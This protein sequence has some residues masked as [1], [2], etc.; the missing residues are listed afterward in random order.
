MDPDFQRAGAPRRLGRCYFFWNVD[1][2][3]FG[4][5]IQRTYSLPSTERLI[6]NC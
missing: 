4:S 5:H 6:F 1:T 3:E 2:S